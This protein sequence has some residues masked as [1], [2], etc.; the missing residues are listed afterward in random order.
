MRLHATSDCDQGLLEAFDG[1]VPRA[2]L[3]AIRRFL[4][5]TVAASSAA[6]R[7]RPDGNASRSSAIQILGRFTPWGARGGAG[8]GVPCGQPSAA[9]VRCVADDTWY[10]C[11]CEACRSGR[12]RTCL[13]NSSLVECACPSKALG[14]SLLD[15]LS[16]EARQLVRKRAAEFYREDYATLPVSPLLSERM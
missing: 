11:S 7:R 10:A 1:A 6:S 3:E 5:R 4:P 15:E 2:T 12:P 8:G 16:V 14:A 9:A 13:S